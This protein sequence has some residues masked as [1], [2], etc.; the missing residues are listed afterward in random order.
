VSSSGTSVH[1]SRTLVFAVRATTHRAAAHWT[2]YISTRQLT[3]R[4]PIRSPGQRICAMADPL[5]IAAAG[6]GFL[7]L[8]GQVLDGVVK[9]REFIA[10][11]DSAPREI[12]DLCHELDIFRGLLEEAGRRVQDSLPMGVDI[13]HL[14]DAFAHCEKMRGYADFMLK[15]LEVNINRSKATTALRYSFKKKEVEGMLLGV[16]RGKTSLLLANQSFES[17]VSPPWSVASPRAM[18]ADTGTGVLPL[19]DM[20]HCQQ[21]R[22]YCWINSAKP[23]ERLLKSC[24]R[25]RPLRTH[26]TKNLRALPM[27]SVLRPKFPQLRQGI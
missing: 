9:L 17:Y 3:K 11:V 13:S 22:I 6:A 25:R 14:K 2:E 18:V 7:S 23:P 27:R 1:H 4:T 21:S 24:Q 26:T 10:T 8:A 19:E 5:S 20:P 12:H 16:E 15:R